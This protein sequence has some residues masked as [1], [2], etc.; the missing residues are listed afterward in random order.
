MF[1]NRRR[2]SRTCIG[3]RVSPPQV[4]KAIGAVYVPAG[5]EVVG[6]ARLEVATQAVEGD[7]TLTVYPTGPQ[8][9]RRTPLTAEELRDVVREWAWA[10]RRGR[11]KVRVFG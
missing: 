3:R 7:W 10:V 8:P 1:P 5:G 2:R 11:G 9:P 4:G 6:V